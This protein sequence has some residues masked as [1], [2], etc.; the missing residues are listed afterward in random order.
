[1]NAIPY[2][3]APLV[4]AA[5]CLFTLVQLLYTESLRLLA[6]DLPILQFFKETLEDRI[7]IS[8]EKGL[9]A[10]SLIKHTLILLLGLCFLAAR[11]GD[12]A[13]VWQSTLEAALFAWL[14][15]LLATYVVPQSL[16]RK[17]TG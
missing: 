13:P 2:I 1:M 17:T 4:T 12:Q 7:G 6:R 8:A 3:L 10:F 5:L 9:L 14:T 15:M 16:Y 11:F